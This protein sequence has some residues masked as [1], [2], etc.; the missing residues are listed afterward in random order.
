MGDGDAYA[1]LYDHVAGPVF[2]LAKRML[3]DERMAEDV[4]QEVLV[5]V[6]RTAERFDPARGSVMTWVLTLAHR[7]T[8]DRVR[9]ERSQADRLEREQVLAT[10]APGDGPAEALERS[11][12]GE[13]LRA[14][15]ATLTVP[16]REAL[17]LAYFGGH[18]YPE[19]ADRLGVP[20]GTVKT[21][22]R[23]GMLRLR[24][25]LDDVR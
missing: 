6:W 10:S 19:V 7:R 20:L 16:Q 13:R 14:A 18:S 9:R 25:R 1:E 11:E 8:V 3:R 15:L 21:R 4:V 2:G 23:Q 12:T 17:E 24:D 5:E 22:I